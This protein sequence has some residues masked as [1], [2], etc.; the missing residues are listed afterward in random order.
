MYKEKRGSSS[1][2]R[3]SDGANI[4][5]TEENMDW[6]AYQQWLS[7]GNTPEPAETAEEI[8]TRE[9]QEINASAIAYLAETD[10]YLLRQLDGGVAMT[11]KMKAERA[12]RRL[13][14]I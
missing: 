2:T 7:E 6:R 5:P 9:Q 14:V 1:I 8:A 13:E 11:A 10:W 12:K 4:P 3:L